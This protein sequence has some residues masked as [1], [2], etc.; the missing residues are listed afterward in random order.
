M[1]NVELFSGGSFIFSD[2][3]IATVYSSDED[4]L[5]SYFEVN[6]REFSEMTTRKFWRFD[7]SAISVSGIKIPVEDIKAMV[8]S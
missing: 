6:L 8:A 7:L 5:Q 1:I 2:D 3:S 4:E